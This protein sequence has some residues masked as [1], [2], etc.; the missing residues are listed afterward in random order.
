MDASNKNKISMVLTMMALLSIILSS[1]CIDFDDFRT[2]GRTA[3][4]RA[5][6]AGDPSICAGAS[7]P[8]VCYTAVAKSEGDASICERIQ[9]PGM[10]SSCRVSAV[11]SGHREESDT[12]GCKYDSECP[13]ICEGNVKWKQGCNPRTGKCIKTF[14][15]DC[16][17][18]TETFGDYSFGKICTKGEC[19]RDGV[20]IEEKK[21]ELMTQKQGLSNE[22]KDMLASKQE[23]QMVWV[24]YYYKRCH[25]ALADVTNKLII[26]SALTLRS[27]PSKMS[28][29]ISSSTQDLIN[30]LLSE[31]TESSTEIS[32]EEF[33][34]WNCNYYKALQ[35]DLT[36]FD[37]KIEL[38]QGEVRELNTQ[39][40][41]F[42]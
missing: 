9:D 23:V 20:S 25:N 38:K 24:P 29:V 41:Q 15:Y 11:A 2:D 40:A 34:S 13:S 28:D 4:E 3:Q 8:D 19:V 26:D 33:I 18:Q 6:A 36:A 10:K 30:A 5:V 1:G 17:K 37:K 35:A 39:I 31:T 12:D 22:V 32:A 14:D 21:Q 16:Q 7:H 42:P 27:P